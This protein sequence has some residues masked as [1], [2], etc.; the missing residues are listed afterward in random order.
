MKLSGIACGSA[1]G[2]ASE[3]SDI[4]LN[5]ESEIRKKP[6]FPQ[7]GSRLFKCNSTLL[8]FSSFLKLPT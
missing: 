1:I 3:N 7:T 4:A 6:T 2:R 5:R 8:Q